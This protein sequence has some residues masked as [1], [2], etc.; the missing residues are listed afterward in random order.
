MQA[1]RAVCE[2][3]KGLRGRERLPLE[4]KQHTTCIHAKNAKAK[5]KTNCMHQPFF[6]KKPIPD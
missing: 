1:K 2:G 3:K 6:P 4:M 5:G